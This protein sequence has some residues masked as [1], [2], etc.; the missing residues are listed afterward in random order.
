MSH[1]YL[2]SSLPHLTLDGDLPFGVEEFG[3]MCEGVL[4][5]AELADVKLVLGLSDGAPQTAVVSDWMAQEK[6]LNQE[7]ACTRAERAGADLKIVQGYTGV[8]E[9]LVDHAFSVSNPG[10]REA[11]LD[12]ARWK[13]VDELGAKDAFGFAA[14]LA[15]AV[16]LKLVARWSVLDAHKGEAKL[17]SLIAESAKV[18]F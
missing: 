16:K 12:K 11:E 4:S 2:V 9:P 13:L 8:V 5:D 18:D 6:L 1:Y 7:I 14:I 10:D 3:A 15:F 17:E